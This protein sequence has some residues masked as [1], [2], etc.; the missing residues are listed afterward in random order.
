[1]PTLQ[2]ALTADRPH[3]A[4]PVIALQMAAMYLGSAAGAALG[5]SLLT[6]GVNAADLAAWAILPATLALAA[7]GWITVTA[8]RSHRRSR[9]VK[10]ETA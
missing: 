6:N 8:L 10:C 4:M 2:Q 3:Q 1:M 7:T 9:T 5:S